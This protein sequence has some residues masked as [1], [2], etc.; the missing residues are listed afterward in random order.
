MRDPSSIQPSD[1]PLVRMFFEQVPESFLIDTCRTLIE[2]YGAAAKYC[3][4]N[5][6]IEQA[7]NLYPYERLATFERN[8]TNLCTRYPGVNAAA[9]LN[10]A[11]NYYH[12]AVVCGS[13]VLT[14]SAVYGPDDI[15]RQAVFRRTYAEDGQTSF[16]FAQQEPLPPGDRR[17]YAIILHGPTRKILRQPGF[18]SVAFPARDCASYIA[19]R[20]LLLRFSGRVSA[21]VVVPVAPPLS[22]L[23]LRPGEKVED[24]ES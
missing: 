10:A 21:G 6:P 12:T 23:T 24:Q 18:I 15:V 2:A 22:P 3:E 7:H 8:W 20:D 5:Y 9:K 11:G 4:E 13:F 1:P 14:E 19:S 17:I 16:P